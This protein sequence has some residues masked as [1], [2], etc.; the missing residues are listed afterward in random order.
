MTHIGSLQLNIQFMIQCHKPGI[1]LNDTYRKV[2]QVE[3][4]STRFINYRLSQSQCRSWR[5]L[6]LWKM[7]KRQVKKCW[8]LSKNVGKS[9]KILKV[10]IVTGEFKFWSWSWTIHTGRVVSTNRQEWI[11]ISK[12]TM[13]WNLLNIITDNVFIW[14]M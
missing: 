10:S 9:E 13:Q 14:L 2:M 12:M 7:F 1:K 8:E 5:G 6:V 11:Y 3:K 4:V